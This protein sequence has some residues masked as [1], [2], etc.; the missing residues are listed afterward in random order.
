MSA[1]AEKKRPLQLVEHTVAKNDPEPKALACYGLLLP[2]T[3]QVWL[4]FV[5]GRPVSGLTTQFLDWC[6]EQ[7]WAQ[8]KKAL[9]LVWDNAGSHISHQVRH[10][11]RAHNQAVKQAARGVR[12]ISC[13]LPSKSPWLNPI[14]PKWRHAKRRVV[15]PDRLL[16]AKEIAERA[17]A[18]L[19]CPYEEHLTLSNKAH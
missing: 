5:D 4:R 7:L 19:G 11:L 17:C 14:E 1:W 15:E 18:A 3:Q 16:G 2:Q 8:G 12:I 10:W 6:C 13:Y 9:V